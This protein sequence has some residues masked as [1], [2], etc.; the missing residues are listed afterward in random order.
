[1]SLLRH[2][3]PIHWVAGMLALAVLC[4]AG[5]SQ[6]ADRAELEKL[7][8]QVLGVTAQLNGNCS[9]TIIYS[10]RDK[11][12]GE[13][14]TLILSAGHCAINKDSDQRIEIPVYQSNE[15]V[16]RDS[17]VGR[18][19]GV[20]YSADLSLWRLKDKQTFFPN[21]AK[22]A[23]EKPA[24]MM[25]EDVWTVGYPLGGVLTI[26]RGLFGS[27]ETSDYDKPGGPITEP[28]QTSRLVPRA[29]L[30]I[31]RMRPATMSCWA[32]P[33]PARRASRF[34]A[35]TRRSPTSTPTSRWPLRVLLASSL[36]TSAIWHNFAKFCQSTDRSRK[37]PTP[38][39]TDELCEQTAALF[40]K[41]NSKKMAADAI[42]I[43]RNTFCSRLTEAAR[44]GFLGPAKTKPGFVIQ[45]MSSKE[46]D[47]WVK[48]VQEPGEEFEVPEGHVVK[49]VSVLVDADGRTRQQWIK[50]RED[51]SPTL[52]AALKAALENYEPAPL[53]PPPS[54]TNGDLLT[55]YPIAD[56]HLGMFSWAKE[57]GA[58]Y[59]LKIAA[60]LL[61]SSMNSLVAR[62]AQSKVAVVLD[63]GDYFHADNS[64]N[65]TAKSG[66]PLDVDSRYAKVVQLGFELVIQCI[67]LALQKHDFVEYR[68]TPGN[69][70]DESSLMLSVAVAAHF[71]AN[72]RVTVDTSP[73]RFYMRQH[74][75]CM[76]TATHGDMLRMGDMAGYVAANWPEA[77]GK[78]RFRYGYTGHIHNEKA[79]SVNSL[80]GLRAESFN[81]LAA[82]DAWHAGEGYQSPRNMVSITLHKD[83]GEVDRFTVAA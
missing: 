58:D 21:V 80:R 47:T 40:L 23:P 53:V 7:Q 10:D 71:R 83:R 4:A 48:Q 29:A 2:I 11:E 76:I 82:K 31:T 32:S 17:Y 63:L 34:L 52:A 65:Q 70:D 15:I 19:Y 45:S 61:R 60:E 6:A 26:T 44:R 51:G 3:R 62:S 35:S 74:G 57:T 38:K 25:G 46:G 77:W 41:Y 1:M 81:T 22:L 5:M 12:S 13:V 39:L 56:L 49:G 72:E 42:G 55:V 27:V 59:D 54:Y 30:S 50:T 33:R 18:V 75:S 37:V 68:K 69:H 8:K 78:T 73:S 67:E 64:R 36:P 66:N 14:T 20:Y 24:L 9:G 28:R 43:P 79:L 16:K